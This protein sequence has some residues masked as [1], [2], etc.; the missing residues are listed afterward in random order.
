VYEV[1]AK[2]RVAALEGIPQSS[3]GA[4]LPLIVA[5]EHRVVL[6]YCIESRPPGWGGSHIRVVDPAVCAEP[7]ALVRF[8]GCW[9]HVSGPPNDEAFTGHPLASRGLHPYGAFR[10]EESSW[11][12]RLERM[13]SVHPR[14]RPDT[15]KTLQH[16]V[17][18]FHDSVFECIC[19]GFEV[20]TDEGIIHRMI[21]TMLEFLI[22]G[23]MGSTPV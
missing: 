13:N 17:F 12:R 15:Y 20:R 2:D 16:L 22:Q 23:R 10:I 1:D 14:H 11:I 4:P 7:L 18:S 19:H 21:P 3:V 8:N 6:A 5:D 9:A